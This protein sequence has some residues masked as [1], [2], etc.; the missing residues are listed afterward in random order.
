MAPVIP[1]MARKAV[2][3]FTYP[4]SFDAYKIANPVP[5]EAS[6]LLAP[7]RPYQKMVQHF[8]HFYVSSVLHCVSYKSKGVDFTYCFSFG[9]YND[10]GC[11]ILVLDRPARISTK[12]DRA[13]L[14]SN[15]HLCHR[16]YSRT[17]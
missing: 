17:R 8:T 16:Y 6:R 10:L 2:M 3:D 4:L 12:L 9:H 13:T 14:W 11:D 5:Q 1:T 15:V 7:L